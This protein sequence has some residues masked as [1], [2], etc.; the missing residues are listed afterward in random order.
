MVN[1]NSPQQAAEM[2]EDASD[3][4]FNVKIIAFATIAI[5]LILISIYCIRVYATKKFRVVQ[6][7]RSEA[8]TLERVLYNDLNYSKYFV[9]LIANQIQDRYYD[10]YYISKVLNNYV[11]SSNFNTL[12]GWRKYSWV[13]A[14]FKEMVTSSQDQPSDTTE[15]LFIKK[16]IE[17]NNWKDRIIFHTMAGTNT[18]NSIILVK[19][20][21][22]KSGDKYLGSVTLTYDIAIMIRRLNSRRKNEHTNFVILDHNL[23]AVARSKPIIDNIISEKDV[24]SP[25]AE[26][27][28]KRTDFFRSFSKEI[29]YLDMISGVN[30]YIKKIDGLPFV[31]LINLDTNEVQHEVLEGVIKKLIE[32]FAVALIFTFLVLA[33]YK[34][35]T[36]L[37]TK[38]ELATLR[39]NKAAKAKSDFLT[40]TAHEI[41][42]PLGFILT[43]SEM[44][45]KELFGPLPVAYKEYAEGIFKNSKLILD[46]MTDILDENQIIEGKFKIINSVEDVEEIIHRAISI[47]RLR[48]NEKK[49]GIVCN[50]EQGLPKLICDKRRILQVISNLIS[51]SFKYSPNDTTITVD[52]RIM[53][54]Q[55]VIEVIDQGMGMSEEDIKSALSAYGISRKQSQNFI[56]SYGLGL[57]IVKMLIDAHDATL[58]IKSVQNSG[59]KVKITFPKYKLMYKLQKYQSGADG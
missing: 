32:V 12:F 58:S 19:N 25:Y 26:R 29:S 35:E 23:K 43:G 30:Y 46:F 28:F 13:N 59:T 39:A 54:E 44:M 6:T 2:P 7:M 51:N 34:R 49:I 14:E 45:T 42:S 55:L 21:A 8:Y 10:N 15:M 52:A 24:L 37:R 40:F 53:E 33:I 36:S 18:N 3:Y 48:Y 47:N 56:E 31:I 11:K 5:A 16:L 1:N 57:L 9:N 22:S 4:N 41:R 20:L 17:G 27:V 38:A 50:I